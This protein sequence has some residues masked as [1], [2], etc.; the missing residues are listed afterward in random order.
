MVRSISISLGANGGCLLV[1]AEVG[2]P[3]LDAGGSSN[4]VVQNRT[5]QPLNS[6]SA[7]LLPGG[8]TT[9][10]RNRLKRASPVERAKGL[11]PSTFS[12]GSRRRFANGSPLVHRFRLR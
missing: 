9:A 7:T 6:H 4:A 10:A 1:L 8:S 5:R 11:E 2:R 3:T 12:L